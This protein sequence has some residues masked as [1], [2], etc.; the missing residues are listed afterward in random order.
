[1]KLRLCG[2]YVY[3]QYKVCSAVHICLLYVN[4]MEIVEI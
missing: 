3:G 4:Y 2:L 1:M